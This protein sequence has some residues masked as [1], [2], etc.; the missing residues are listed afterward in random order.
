MEPV[1]FLMAVVQ[2]F[3]TLGLVCGYG[4]VV[5]DMAQAAMNAHTQKPF[6]AAKFNRLL[7][8]KPK[9]HKPSQGVSK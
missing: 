5:R 2:V 7:W 1:R 8:G 9:N 3:F 6:S 4:A